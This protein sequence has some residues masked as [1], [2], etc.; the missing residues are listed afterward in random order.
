MRKVQI[1]LPFDDLAVRVVR[2]F[3][4]ERWPANQ[5]LKHNCT[6]APPVATLVVALSIVALDREDFWSDV[7][8][9]ADGGVRELSPR[10]AP[11]IDLRTIRD[12]EINLVEVDA[13]A[14]VGDAIS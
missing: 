6:H 13:V 11:G 8:R 12:G 4:A 1:A 10:L 3:G 2:I 7:V 9:R 14:V 5:A